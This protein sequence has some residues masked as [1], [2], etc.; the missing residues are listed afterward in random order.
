MRHGGRGGT[1]SCAVVASVYRRRLALAPVRGGTPEIRMARGAALLAAQL[2]AAAATV[3]SGSC[4]CCTGNY[5]SATYV[6]VGSSR[7]DCASRYSSCAACAGSSGSCSYGSSSYSSSSSSSSRRRSSSPSSPPS[8]GANTGEPQESHPCA[9][10]RPP[11]SRP[12]DTRGVLGQTTCRR[13]RL[14]SQTVPSRSG[15][16]SG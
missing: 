2:L 4:R 11:C 16:P 12:T 5:C 7:S 10:H 6:G 13:R 9:E 3:A 1:R 15:R 14:W 8:T